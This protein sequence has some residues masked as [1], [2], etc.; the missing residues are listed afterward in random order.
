MERCIR[1]GVKAD[2]V[3]LYDAIYEGRMSYLCER[4]S[5]IENIPI[6]R[7][8]DSEHI[9][10]SEKGVG[11]YERMKLMAGIKD[12]K[13]EDVLFR[14]EKLRELDK[15]PRLEAPEKPPLKLIEYYHWEIMRHRRKKGLSQKQLAEKIGVSEV[16]IEMLEKAKI[17]DNAE[18]II[19]KLENFFLMRL[20][21]VSEIELI[22]RMRKTT[23]KPV[24]RDEFGNVLETVPEP[25]IEE[26][27]EE[28]LEKS[29]D[30]S[31]NVEIE[32][33]DIQAVRIGDLRELHK[34]KVEVSKEEKRAE[35]RQIEER[36]SLIEARK[37][38][39]RMMRE[40]ESKNIDNILGGADLL[41]K[42]ED[43]MDD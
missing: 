13:K 23:G 19:R 35:Q 14:K 15:N 43:E 38:E 36:Q 21:K 40:K 9:K 6:I 2:I 25:K 24:L 37:E 1:C 11:V 16:A 42:E 22:E 10:E 30:D 3:K 41:K 34:K 39:L 29:I 32:K 8:P 33:V 26:Y 18:E 4:C 17:P 28:K 12:V 27:S 20:R 7:Q 5:I 31:G